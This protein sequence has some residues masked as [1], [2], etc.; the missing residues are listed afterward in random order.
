ML[1]SSFAMSN[2]KREASHTATTYLAL[3]FSNRPGFS[4]RISM[5]SN[6]ISAYFTLNP[7]NLE[8]GLVSNLWT[9]IVAQ[10]RARAQLATAARLDRPRNSPA[11]VAILSMV[12]LSKNTSR[13]PRFPRSVRG[14]VFG[15][16]AVR[17]RRSMT[18]PSS[19]GS[20]DAD[21]SLDVVS[22]RLG[23]GLVL[24]GPLGP[25]VRGLVQSPV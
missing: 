17:E 3:E 6:F 7:T 10:V 19:H 4:P 15:P 1:N 25:L 12:A 24:R 21:P 16:R 5:V 8:Y 13:F 14:V 20:A 11:T 18:N 22:H 2:A 23:G 9:I